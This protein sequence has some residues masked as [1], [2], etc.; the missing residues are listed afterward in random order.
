MTVILFERLGPYHLARLEA[1]GQVLELTCLELFTR[2]KTYAWDIT[3]GAKHFRRI[4]LFGDE[5]GSSPASTPQIARRVHAALDEADPLV[6]AVPG[7]A[8]P[9]ALTAMDWCVR[10]QRRIVMMSESTAEDSP[11]FFFKE[12]VKRRIVGGF[13]AAGLVGGRPHA[14]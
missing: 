10:R 3:E 8:T 13:S 6:V 11:R 9:L 2:D 4:R 1:A 12:A 14:K 7:W 5:G